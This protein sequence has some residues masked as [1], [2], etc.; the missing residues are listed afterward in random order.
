MEARRLELLPGVTLTAIRSHR[1]KTGYHSLNLMLPLA[2]E[3][4]ALDAL[5]PLVLRRGS[6]RHPDMAGIAAELDEL[7]GGILEPAIRKRGE[8]HCVGFSASV[9]DDAFV[10]GGERLLERTVGLLGELLLEPAGTEGFVPAY[11]EGER[12][13]LIDQIRAQINDKRQYA[14]NRLVELMC[15]DEPFGVGRLGTLEQARAITA[16]ELYRRYRQVL[17]QGRIALFY[18]GSAGAD[19]VGELW[20]SA[21]S[22]LPREGRGEEAPLPAPAPCPDGPRE[23]TEELDVTQ[24]KLAMGFRTGCT[25]REEGYPALMLFNALYGGGATSRLFL[26]VREK[27]SLC[28]YASSS[29]ERLKGVMLVSCG[30]DPERFDQA[31]EEI[32]EQFRLCRAG[33]FEDWELEAARASLVSALRSALDQQGRLEDFWLGQAAAGLTTG[34]EELADRLAVIGRREVV[35]AAEGVRL[36]GIYFLK[37]RGGSPCQ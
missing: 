21:L 9:L 5:L 17:A 14:Q 24:G 1:F 15:P 25:A 10:P 32:L 13:N 28:Y 8:T 3:T 7:Y 23:W 26:H 4:A 16:G 36:A 33:K 11:V 18:C 19:E 31:R 20:K 34:P 30:I 27:Q 2:R 37:G 22:A 12:E 29:L 35:A 6:R